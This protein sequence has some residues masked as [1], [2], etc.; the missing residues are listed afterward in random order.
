M[1]VW[2]FLRKYAYEN[3]TSVSGAVK[4]IVEKEMEKE[5]AETVK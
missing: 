2:H 4:M 1:S 5:N 3:E